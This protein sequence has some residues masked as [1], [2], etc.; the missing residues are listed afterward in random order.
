MLTLFTDKYNIYIIFR[1]R[2]WSTLFT[3]TR[4]SK[5]RYDTIISESGDTIVT[6]SGD[7]VTTSEA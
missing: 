3:P 2:E 7:R 1:N 4:A 6:E 5:G